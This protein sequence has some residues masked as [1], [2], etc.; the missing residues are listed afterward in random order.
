[1]PETFAY[2]ALD[3]GRALLCRDCAEDVRVGG[4]RT[5]P[6]PVMPGIME[7]AWCHGTI[8]SVAADAAPKGAA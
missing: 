1:M 4:G 2:H 7:C 3:D 8:G 5:R 6:H